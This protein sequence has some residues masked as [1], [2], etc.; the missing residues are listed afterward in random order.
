M[1]S[2]LFWFGF[3]EQEQK[4]E[5]RVAVFLCKGCGKDAAKG[6]GVLFSFHNPAECRILT[7]TSENEHM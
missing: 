4:G 2:L 5:E 1:L 7:L 6:K 3:F